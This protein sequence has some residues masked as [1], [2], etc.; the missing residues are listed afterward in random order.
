MERRI[1]TTTRAC[2]ARLVPTGDEITIPAG[3]FVTL[4]QALGGTFT[5]VLEGNMAR[6]AGHDADALGLPV[7]VLEFPLPDAE[8]VAEENVWHAL[9]SVYDPEIPVSIA[10]L[11]LVY[12]VHIN[13]GRVDIRMT[14]TAPGC[15]MGPVLVEEVKER[16]AT[17]PHV[18]AVEVELVFDPPWSRDMMT[19]EAQLQLGVF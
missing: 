13:D 16:V 7:E 2:S 1:V 19:E 6:I 15:G 18:S 5:V 4:T 17:V 12:S 14:L 8:T 11:G 10:E 3:T 9:N